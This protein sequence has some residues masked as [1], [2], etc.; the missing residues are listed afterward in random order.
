MRKKHNTMLFFDKKLIKQ[1]LQCRAAIYKTN[2]YY[3]ETRLLHMDK[4]DLLA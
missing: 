4:Y 1:P 2:R 3:C